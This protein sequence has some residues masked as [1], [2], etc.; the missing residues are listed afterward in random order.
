MLLSSIFIFLNA[1][2]WFYT[3]EVV[4]KIVH[5]AKMNAAPDVVYGDAVS[6]ERSVIGP[7]EC[8][9]EN[10]QESMICHQA[11]FASTS[12]MKEQKFDLNY[13]IAADYKF[14]LGLKL[15]G[16]TFLKVDMP[17]AYYSYDGVSTV[18]VKA[19]YNEHAAIKEL[20][21]IPVDRKV[22]EKRIFKES[23]AQKIKNVL[24]TKLWWWWSVK[25]KGKTILE[26]NLKEN[27]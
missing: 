23:F 11:L 6:V 27:K 20:Y 19:R 9:D 8:S 12:L 24:P 17:I 21:G 5:A 25:I 13:K 2:D 26:P 22:I 16:K 14:V 4:E 3:S 10:I 18:N 7:I 1:G 15:A